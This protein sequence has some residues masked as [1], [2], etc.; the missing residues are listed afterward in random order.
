MT[1][2]MPRLMKVEAKRLLLNRATWGILAAAIAVALV[3]TLQT[4][5]PSEEGKQLWERQAWLLTAIN[6]QLFMLVLGAKFVTDD[7]RH[8]TIIPSALIT[9]H[10]SRIVVSKL[11]VLAA[12][13]GAAAAIVA[14][15]VTGA[16]WTHLS[17]GL[18]LEEFRSIAGLIV[19]GG[20]FAALGGGVGFVVRNQVGAVV[21]VIVWTMVFGQILGGLSDAVTQFLPGDAGIALGI[22]S[23]SEATL[24]AGLI[25]MLYTVGVGLMGAVTMRKRDV[26]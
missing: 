20:L 10:R 22:G 6:V 26:L 8:G 1:K 5:I 21:G 4:Q 13:G 12:A 3:S 23:T 15:V 14:G 18:Q 24:Y 25:L 9:P 16:S 2:L 19:A 7:F 11:V 17:N